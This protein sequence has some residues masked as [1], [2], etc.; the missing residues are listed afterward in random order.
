MIHRFRAI[1]VR[2]PSHRPALMLAPVFLLPG[3]AA[4]GTDQGI[5]GR[6]TRGAE[7]GLT[8]RLPPQALLQF[9]TEHLRL[10]GPINVVAFS[11]DGRLVAA[12][13]RRGDGLGHSNS[14]IATYEAASGRTLREIALD[15]AIAQGALTPDDRMLVVATSHGVINDTRFHGVELGTGRIRWTIPPGEEKVLFPTVSAMQC[16]SGSPLVEVAMLEGQVVRLNALTGR[17]QR[18]SLADSRTAEQKAGGWTPQLWEG[19]FS[20]DGRTLAG[21]GSGGWI[22]AWDVE[23]STVR[24]RIPA[25]QGCH[26]A[27]APDGQTLATADIFHSDDF[28]RDTIR[29]IDVVTGRPILALEPRDDRATVLAFSPDGS[30]LFSGFDRGTAIIW[31]VRRGQGTPGTR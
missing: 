25:L 22:C 1:F 31:D 11:P 24:A 3:L 28:G 9:G 5:P 12:A 7:A 21:W 19:T 6:S 16:R 29:L 30:K 18:R 20:T 14:I 26:M 8:H 27:L 15:D 10:R 13:G 17:E 2:V 23:S 4:A